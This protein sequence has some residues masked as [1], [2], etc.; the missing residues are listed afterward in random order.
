[1]N[2]SGHD[3]RRTFQRYLKPSKEGTRRRMDTVDAQRGAWTPAADELGGHPSVTVRAI[4]VFE[5][6]ADH[7]FKF[8]SPG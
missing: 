5:C 4:G 8:V 2:L 6:L 1:M 3:D 7:D